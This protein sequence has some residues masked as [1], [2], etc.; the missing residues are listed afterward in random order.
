MSA[1]RSRTVSRA[2]G[3]LSRSSPSQLAI[4][5]TLRPSPSLSNLNIHSH[6]TSS[7]HPEVMQST[8]YVLDSSASSVI[9]M[10]PGEGILIQDIDAQTDAEDVEAID[11]AFVS[12]SSNGQ[13]QLLRDQLRS[14]SHRAAQ[15]GRH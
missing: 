8:D 4:S 14:L 5:P 6:N 15:S 12:T 11:K 1:P 3:P 2:G 13:K 7:S 9:D 10:D